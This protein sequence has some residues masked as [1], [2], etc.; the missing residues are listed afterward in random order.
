MYKLKFFKQVIIFIIIF[1]SNI[2][3]IICIYYTL[4]QISLINY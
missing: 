3:I 4:F 2:F 1:H